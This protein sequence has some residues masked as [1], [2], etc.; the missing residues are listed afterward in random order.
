[1]KSNRKTFL[2]RTRLWLSAIDPLPQLAL[3]GLVCGLLTGLVIIAFRLFIET[4]QAGL[5]PLGNPENYEDLSPVLRL[6]IPIVGAL[7]IGLI[8]DMI[9]RETRQ[10]GIV[11]VMERFMYHEGRLPPANAAWQFI[12]AALSIIS[13]H[14]VGREGPGVHLGAATGSLMG[15][16]LRLPDN[17]NRVLVSCGAAASIAASF[18]T[19]LAGVIFAME[20]I[21]REYSLAGFTPVILAA[22]SA[23]ALSR[24]VFGDEPVFTIPLLDM[25]S[26]WE[27]SF[28][29]LSGL[30]IGALAALFIR[31]LRKFT[32]LWRQRGLWQRTLLAGVITG[33][34]AVFVPQIMG[35]GYDT[36]N[37]TLAGQAGF[38]LLLVIVFFKML[39]T[40]ACVGLGLPGGFIG[41]TLVIGACAG[42][43]LG[44]VAQSV[45][46]GQVTGPA[47]YAVIGMAAM[48]G[49][50]LQAP[51]AALIAIIELTADPHLILPGML[52]VIT[53][54][55]TCSELFKQPAVFDM[56]LRERGLDFHN[57]PVAQSL[58]IEGVVRVM[59]QNFVLTPTRVPGRE[60]RKM[61]RENP[62]WIV[63]LSES[64]RQPTV[65]PASNL[66]QYLAENEASLSRNGL[67]DLMDIPAQ[68][69]QAA[70]IDKRAT[71]QES[72]EVLDRG[73]LDMA[74]VAADTEQPSTIVGIISRQDIEAYYSAAPQ[75]T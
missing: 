39:A 73:N 30:L 37:L 28:V 35:V 38:V 5:L 25:G 1:M 66:A 69:S 21:A 2:E 50:V 53:A 63:L 41:P 7:L 24:L 22:V 62:L 58:R 56:L 75:S 67:I 40:S 36:I 55:L 68:R 6:L 61:L 8:F 10:M 70:L 27:L 74:C 45:F 33:I 51:L 13:G 44:I 32:G 52:A 15:Q 29:L 43:A 17:S 54:G 57:D 49:A 60:A 46:P 19:P 11:H 64:G 12:G 31:M 72:L 4:A 20:V 16:S 34:T 26:L 48:M 71:L 18:N 42:G 47:F 23:T 65:M 14:S 3:I 9:A 59:E